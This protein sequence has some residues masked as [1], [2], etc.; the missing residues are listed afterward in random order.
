MEVTKVKL[1]TRP[2]TAIEKQSCSEQ[3][4]LASLSSS[5]PILQSSDA[6]D[7]AE[8][9]KRPNCLINI[10]HFDSLA[11][12]SMAIKNEGI[13]S[14][15]L[16]FGIDYTM[17][18]KIMGKNTFNGMSLHHISDTVVN[19]YQEVICILGDTL[20]SISEGSIA[21]YGFGDATVKD[22]GIFPL[23][24]EGECGGFY[25]VLDVYNEKTPMIK[26]AGPTN[27]APM[28]DEATRIAF[29][30]QQYQILIIVAD[31]QVT[32]EEETIAAIVAA[33]RYPVSIVVIGVGD[34]PWDMMREFDVKL[35]ERVFDNFNFVDF[36]K[37]KATARNP[38]SAVALN[39]LMEIPDQFRAIK[40]F[41]LLET[42]ERP[43]VTA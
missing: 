21:V 16:I 39:A 28:I 13:E 31:G 32:K 6:D 7:E 18:N 30:K 14:C 4:K 36:H 42:M 29:R 41:R 35:P 23:K 1:E 37:V 10:D 5:D 9:E 19:P 24:S 27:F 22:K 33:S 8:V 11:E 43:P 17:S 12:V 40:Q 38:H 3:L 25:E 2:A 26:L 20:E 34:G 15:G